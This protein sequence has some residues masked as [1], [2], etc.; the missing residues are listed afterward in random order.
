MALPRFLYSVSESI[1]EELLPTAE[2]EDSPCVS[3]SAKGE[4]TGALSRSKKEISQSPNLPPSF[5][6]FRPREDSEQ[7]RAAENRREMEFG[8]AA[9]AVELSEPGRH[10]RAR[11]GDRGERSDSE[12]TDS[13]DSGGVLETMGERRPEKR[14]K[15]NGSAAAVQEG[16]KDF[17]GINDDGSSS[18]STRNRSYHLSGRGSTRSGMYR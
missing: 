18:Q 13:D 15:K 2:R 9:V 1:H 5:A 8:G 4:L 17:I 11:D 14:R 16:D 3:P 12:S 7:E 6:G 10:T